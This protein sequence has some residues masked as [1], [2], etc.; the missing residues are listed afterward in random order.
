MCFK[1]HHF[2]GSRDTHHP[3]SMSD[4]KQAARDET[5]YRLGVSS[6]DSEILQKAGSGSAKKRGKSHTPGEVKFPSPDEERTMDNAGRES[7]DK[8]KHATEQIAKHYRDSS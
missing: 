7:A 4:S 8:R 5:N 2:A 3:I 1:A 6:K